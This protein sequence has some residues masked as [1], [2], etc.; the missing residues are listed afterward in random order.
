MTKKKTDKKEDAKFDLATALSNV[1]RYLKEGFLEFIKEE[2][3]TSQKQFDEL[4]N[5]YKEFR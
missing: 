3:V 5:D 2:K 4:Y 1:N